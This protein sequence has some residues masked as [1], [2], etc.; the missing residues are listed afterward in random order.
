MAG[1][2]A[3][4][5]HEPPAREVVRCGAVRCGGGATKY[6]KRS[7]SARP[8]V[9]VR[10]YYPRLF[11]KESRHHE[12]ADAERRLSAASAPAP[13]TARRHVAQERTVRQRVVPALGVPGRCP[14]NGLPAPARLS[15]MVRWACA[16]AKAPS[17]QA[18]R[19]RRLLHRA[20]GWPPSSVACQPP[21]VAVTVVTVTEE[22]SGVYHFFARGSTQPKTAITHQTQACISE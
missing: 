20:C 5:R 11:V 12:E 8:R 3:A 6:I 7:T 9:R 19:W 15:E 4:L 1:H 17:R 21:S 14:R 13:A 22:L 18:A 16:T 2:G 10:T